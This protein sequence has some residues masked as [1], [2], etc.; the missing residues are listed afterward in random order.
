ML[1]LNSKYNL[2]PIKDLL[3]RQREDIQII[4]NE[5]YKRITIQGKAKGIIL[6]DIETG[7]NIGTKNQFIVRNGQFLI[8]KIDARNGAYGIIPEDL[9]G[10]IITGNFWTY[11]INEDLV[12]PE[13]LIYLMKHEFFIQMCSICSYGSTNRWYLDEDTF[14]NF[15]IPLPDKKEQKKIYTYINEIEKAKQLILNK[16]K[17]ISNMINQIVGQ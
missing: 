1:S 8:S 10:G 11:K 17:D 13:F 4:D 7:S 16:E 15:K 2:V 3:F 6:R 5:Q 14:Y 12:L 9:D